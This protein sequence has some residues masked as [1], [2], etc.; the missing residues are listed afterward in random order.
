MTT[1]NGVPIVWDEPSDWQKNADKP[2]AK[3]AGKIIT[4]V[5]HHDDFCKDSEI[6]VLSGSW[7]IAKVCVWENGSVTFR[8]LPPGGVK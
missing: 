4:C 8:M 2:V 6:V 1:Y 3:L 5:T 7:G